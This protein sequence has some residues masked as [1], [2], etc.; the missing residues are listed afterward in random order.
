MRPHTATSSQ[1]HK[2]TRSVFLLLSSTSLAS[3]SARS[4]LAL[5]P[6][7]PPPRFAA[8]R[9]R[10]SSL[11][12]LTRCMAA[13]EPRTS[14]LQVQSVSSSSLLLLLSLSSSLL[15]LPADAESAASR[16]RRSMPQRRI[17]SLL[18][19]F[20]SSSALARLMRR[21][22]E[23]KSSRQ[24]LLPRSSHRLTVSCRSFLLVSLPFSSSSLALSSNA[25]NTCLVCVAANRLILPAIFH[26]FIASSSCSPC[27]A[28]ATSLTLLLLSSQSPHIVRLLA[29]INLARLVL[30]H[31]IVNRLLLVRSVSSTRQLKIRLSAHRCWRAKRMLLARLLVRSWKSTCSSSCSTNR[32]HRILSLLDINFLTLPITPSPPHSSSCPSP[33]TIFLK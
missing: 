31:V 18:P 8:C 22:E 19:T 32:C 4:A 29:N 2:I 27:R 23:A 14:S 24:L 17:R 33:S 20:P 6:L 5:P 7:P 15:A 28:A 25:S 3:L 30:I 1:L 10:L 13:I 16:Q 26:S 11:L 21:Q 9:H 12:V